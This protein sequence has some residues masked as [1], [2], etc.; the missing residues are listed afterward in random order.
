MW[1]AKLEKRGAP[2]LF[3]YGKLL[4]VLL[5]LLLLKSAAVLVFA[6]NAAPVSR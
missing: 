6:T 4:L 1:H 5:L 3:I 2:G